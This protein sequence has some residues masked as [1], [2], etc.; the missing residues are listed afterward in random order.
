MKKTISLILMLVLA[1]GL[2]TGCSQKAPVNTSPDGV[3]I[4]MASAQHTPNNHWVFTYEDGVAADG[5]RLTAAEMLAQTEGTRVIPTPFTVENGGALDNGIY[6]V[7]D[8][9]GNEISYQRMVFNAPEEAG[10]YLCVVEMTFGNEK[11]Y[12]GYQ[13]FFRFSVTE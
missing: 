11:V 5:A 2:L 8:L 1:L 13:I 6:S 12:S 9:E 10:E 3:V 4:K 7:Y